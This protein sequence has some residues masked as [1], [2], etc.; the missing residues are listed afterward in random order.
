M[1]K[2]TKIKKIQ[3]NDV[4]LKVYIYQKKRKYSKHVANLDNFIVKFQNMLIIKLIYF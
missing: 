1:K 3:A 4:K 2:T